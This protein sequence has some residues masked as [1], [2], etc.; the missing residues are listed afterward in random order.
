MDITN[1]KIIPIEVRDEYMLGSGVSIGARGSYDSV[2]LKVKFDEK[3]QGLNKYATW[4]DALGNDVD[5]TLVTALAL[6]DGEPDTYYIP[7]TAPVTKHAGTVKLSFTGYVVSGDSNKTVESLINTATGSFRV[8]ESN[9]TL[10][11]DGSVNATLAQELYAAIDDTVQRLV[12]V[13]EGE[14][15]RDSQY[16]AR[17][18]ARDSDFN[19]KQDQRQTAFNDAQTQR[20]TDFNKEQNDRASEWKTEYASR[21]AQLKNFVNGLGIAQA[22]GDSESQVMS[23]KG[24]TDLAKM[25]TKC[26]DETY[27]PLVVEQ[28]KPAMIV[29]TMSDGTNQTTPASTTIVKILSDGSYQ[30]NTAPAFATTDFIPVNESTTIKSS[31]WMYASQTIATII[32]YDADKNLHSCVANTRTD[33]QTSFTFDVT[34]PEGAKYARLTFLASQKSNWIRVTTWMRAITEDNLTHESGDSAEKV[35]SQKATTEYV[36]GYIPKVA[37]RNLANFTFERA[38]IDTT[39]GEFKP[40]ASGNADCASPDYVEVKGDTS[41]T[42]SCDPTTLATVSKLMVMM[43][44]SDKAFITYVTFGMDLVSAGVAIKT[45]ANCCYI[46]VYITNSGSTDWQSLIPSKFQIEFG[47]KATEYIP[48]MIID[49]TLL[50]LSQNAG[51]NYSAYG[52]P[53]LEFEG[54]ITGISKDNAVTLSYKYGDRTGSCT[55]KW[56]GSSSLS[57]PKKNYT[58][59]F[60]DGAFEAK[61]GWGEHEKYCLKANYIDFSHSRN[62]CS[63]KLWGDVVKSRTPA[64]ATLNALPNAGAID[65]FPICVVINGEYKGIYT[66]NIPKDGW[67]FGMGDEDKSEQMAILCANAADATGS[68]ICTFKSNTATGT[69]ADLEI[70]YVTDENNTQWVIDSVNRL[71]IECIDCDSEAYFDANVAPRLDVESAIDYYI[72]CL[73]TQNLDGISKNYLLSTYNGKKWFFSAYDLD[74]T[75]GLWTNGKRLIPNDGSGDGYAQCT[76]NALNHRVFELIRLYKADELKERYKNLTEG[77]TEAFRNPLSEDRVVDTFYNFAGSIP[78]ALLDEEVKLWPTLPSTSVNNVS[79]IIDHYRRRR[80]FIDPQIEAL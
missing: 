19:T 62:I 66:F 39:N 21:E 79:Q 30:V 48:P 28:G 73:I 75:F 70:E 44:D 40:L 4:T 50:D 15:E 41:Y 24:A 33:G 27:S 46:R 32:F 11:D 10:L 34:P 77:Y 12:D 47:D 54:D 42:F 20:Q 52:L 58:I 78:K 49:P 3:W 17:E 13:E 29:K 8:L 51:F 38:Y 22:P 25:I 37:S 65:G 6:V 74:S 35:M 56:Q 31:E 26:V 80:A 69:D 53:V 63:A 72:F 64:N 36:S 57:Y 2:I 60:K 16:A 7:V 9:A 14:A 23:Q 1:K 76:V 59:K 5:Q 45:R 67:M 43:Y 68:Q 71:I 61:A 18:N 55:L